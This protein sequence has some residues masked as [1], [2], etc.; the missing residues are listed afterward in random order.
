MGEEWKS[1]PSGVHIRFPPA[2]YQGLL[3]CGGM[4]HCR[5]VRSPFAGKSE[6]EA[7]ETLLDESSHQ[8]FRQAVRKLIWLSLLSE[9]G[10]RVTAP[11]LSDLA[12]LKRC[13]RYVHGTQDFA[14]RVQLEQDDSLDSDVVTKQ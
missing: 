13:L 2:Y 1:I 8:Q 14:L 6:R 7:G 12:A 11:T 9:L 10:R 3:D 5:A 4:T